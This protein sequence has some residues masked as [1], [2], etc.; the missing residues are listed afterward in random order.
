M[1]KVS[2]YI[3]ICIFLKKKKKITT[4]IGFSYKKFDGTFYEKTNYTFAI[5]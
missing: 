4:K 1:A 3:Y 5:M 2:N